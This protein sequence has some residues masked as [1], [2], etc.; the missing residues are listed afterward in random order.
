MAVFVY[1]CPWTHAQTGAGSNNSWLTTTFSKNIRAAH[2]NNSALHRGRICVLRFRL[3]H[4]GLSF[5]F[6]GVTSCVT[7]LNCEFIALLLFVMFMLKSW[8]KKKFF[9]SSHIYS[10]PP[11]IQT[12]FQIP[13]ER[14][15]FQYQS[16][17]EVDSCGWA[18]S[19][20][21][22]RASLVDASSLLK[23]VSEWLLL[24]WQ[25]CQQGWVHLTP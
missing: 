20:N 3:R 23:L 14:G 8:K 16:V 24:L 17:A 12:A 9:Q 15:P 5:T 21:W 18:I 19:I 10:D 6:N 4:S 2:L 25:S 13:R 7:E 11:A 1:V 22:A